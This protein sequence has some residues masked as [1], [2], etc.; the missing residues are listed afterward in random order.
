MLATHLSCIGDV[1]SIPGPWNDEYRS[2]LGHELASDYSVPDGE[3]RCYRN[4][5]EQPQYLIAD[6]I[7]IRHILEHVGNVHGGFIKGSCIRNG[8]V[9]LIT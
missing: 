4:C 2:I 3:T 8:L 7:E 5:R 9:N 6:A 1:T